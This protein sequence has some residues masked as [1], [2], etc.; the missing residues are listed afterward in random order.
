MK[1]FYLV[2]LLICVCCM[3][4][5]VDEAKEVVSFKNA[6][7]EVNLFHFISFVISQIYEN[8]EVTSMLA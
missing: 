6:A 3:Q 2:V 5:S 8:V 7:L 1:V 4:L